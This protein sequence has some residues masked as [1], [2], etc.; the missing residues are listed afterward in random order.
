MITQ[1]HPL[2]PAWRLYQRR[3][4]R[5]EQGGERLTLRLQCLRHQ[6]SGFGLGA[7]H[8]FKEK[9]APRPWML[10][11]VPLRPAGRPGMLKGGMKGKRERDRE[12]R[13]KKRE[14]KD[15][16][17]TSISQRASVKR[18]NAKH[19]AT[20]THTH[21]HKHTHTSIP[22]NPC[23][24]SSEK[25]VRNLIWVCVHFHCAYGQRKRVACLSAAH[26][27]LSVSLLYVFYTFSLT[28][29]ICVSWLQSKDVSFSSLYICWLSISQSVFFT[30]PEHNKQLLSLT[31]YHSQ[32][33]FICFIVRNV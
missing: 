9:P 14:R 4:G 12:R 30:P 27:L 29:L 6:L 28:Y 32:F 33:N 7:L 8:Y 18:W 25:G 11:L 24:K 21:K 31:I 5:D 15:H 1:S 2:S 17:T 23:T 26:S 16:N 3:V 22:T 19:W 10:S 20:F 13:R